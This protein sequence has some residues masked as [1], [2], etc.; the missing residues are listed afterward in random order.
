M[1]KVQAG[2]RLLAPSRLESR[3]YGRLENLRY[4]QISRMRL[5]FPTVTPNG[6]G[7]NVVTLAK[8]YRI[9]EECRMEYL[10]PVWPACPHVQPGSRHG[11]GYYLKPS[12][13]EK[14]KWRMVQCQY[15]AQRAFGFELWPTLVFDKTN[16]KESAH[17]DV[18]EAC[19]DYLRA[20]GLDDPRRSVVVTTNGMWGQYSGIRR[21]RPWILELLRSHANS[22]ERFAA[23]ERRAA[24]RFW[25][26]VQI[27]MGD[28]APRDAKGAIVG[29]ERVV[30]LPLEW[31]TRI[32]HGLRE[33]CDPFFVLVTDGTPEE[34]ADFI[35]TFDPVHLIGQPYKDFLGV[36]LMS[37]A[38][39]VVG[40]NSTYSRLGVFL[41]DKPY[42]WCAET[43]FKDPTGG[44][45]YL[46]NEPENIAPGNG[47]RSAPEAV[48]R[49]FALSANVQALPPG[50]VRYAAAGGRTPIEID[51][52]LLYH[53]PVFLFE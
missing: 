18:G 32:C 2:V 41:N 6:F 31:Y 25:V 30:R 17:V 5:V 22:R 36:L 24:G 51:D 1:W 33:I 43:L 11:Y 12:P 21:A 26:T 7:N 39:L 52:D 35:K 53:Q 34:L 13:V 42:I 16:Y 38:D 29:G 47:D 49:C 40:S 3:R 37:R 28:F 9:A 14:L 23:I 50:L 10:P 44:Y 48:R 19:L 15:R 46:W 8:A 45:G 20:R 27:R 4:N